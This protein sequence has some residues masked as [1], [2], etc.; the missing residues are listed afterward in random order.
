MASYVIK[1]MHFPATHE[2]FVGSKTIR[3]RNFVFGVLDY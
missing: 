2:G 1:N 3:P